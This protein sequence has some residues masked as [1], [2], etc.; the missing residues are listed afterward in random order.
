[1][2]KWI[3]LNSIVHMFTVLALEAW[4]DE[5]CTVIFC[6]LTGTEKGKVDDVGE[7][8]ALRL[9][10]QLCF[11]LYA[12]AKEVVRKYKPFLDKLDLTYTQYISMMV[13]WEMGHISEKDLGTKLFLD[14]GTLT[15]VLKKL[16]AKK[17]ITRSRSV[18]DER[19]LIVNLT[20]E[21]KKLRE[22]AREIPLQMGSCISLGADEFKQLYVLLYK[23][24]GNLR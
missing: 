14:S 18:D 5:T 24:L 11:P 3:L 8:D 22:S 7:F 20:K 4:A 16:E 9:E 13:I 15:P 2:Y 10:N 23:V 19:S 1:M 12:C 6:D 17:Y 21:G